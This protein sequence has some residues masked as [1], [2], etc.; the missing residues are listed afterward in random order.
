[1]EERSGV[2]KAPGER[3]K[4]NKTNCLRF[5]YLPQPFLFGYNPLVADASDAVVVVKGIDLRKMFRFVNG[6]QKQKAEVKEGRFQF[7]KEKGKF[8][9]GKKD[10]LRFP[11]LFPDPCSFAF[12]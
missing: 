7:D 9:K 4:R 5:Y 3:Q 10:H 11:F 8:L 6:L 1:M 2:V 12:R